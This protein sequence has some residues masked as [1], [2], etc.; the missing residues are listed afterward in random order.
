M[1][2]TRARGQAYEEKLA[3]E[4]A[5]AAEARELSAELAA[6]RKEADAKVAP[7]RSSDTHAPLQRTRMAFPLSHLIC[8]AD[9]RAWPSNLTSCR[10]TPVSHLMRRCSTRAWPPPALIRCPTNSA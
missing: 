9:T 6:V 7:P 3:L 1:A 10:H 2:T 5:R 8:A 4:A